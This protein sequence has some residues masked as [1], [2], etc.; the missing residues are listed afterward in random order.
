MSSFQYR[1]LLIPF[2]CANIT[3]CIPIH[4]LGNPKVIL[5]GTGWGISTLAEEVD[6]RKIYRRRGCKS[7]LCIFFTP[8]LQ[9]HIS[10]F[11]SVFIN[12]YT[13]AFC[14]EI[15]KLLPNLCSKGLYKDKL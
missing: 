6:Y 14:Y 2:K 12:E 15:F 4:G 1:G 8:I 5:V 3:D 9:L 11:N 10:G 7:N 13:V